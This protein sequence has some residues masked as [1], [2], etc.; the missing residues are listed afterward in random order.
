MDDNALL[1]SRDEETQHLWELRNILEH[2][3][4]LYEKQRLMLEPAVPPAIV[5]GLAET[6]RELAMVEGKL[7]LPPSTIEIA[8]A[9][10]ITGQY[11]AIDF[12][13]RFV[14]KQLR[15]GLDRMGELLQSA[16]DDSVLWRKASDIGRTI[17]QK[18]TLV[19]VMLI[20]AALL[21]LA[22]GMLYIAATLRARG[23]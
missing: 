6:I 8:E 3:R 4:R 10:G 17:G 21:V 23:F 16:Q 14:E 5:L 20:A 9:V 11:A 15:E 1:V 19:A 18:R 12:R 13:L 7:S 2:R 22:G